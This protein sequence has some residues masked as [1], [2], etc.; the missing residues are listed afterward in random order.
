LR[1]AWLLI[2]LASACFGVCAADIRWRTPM[3]S[4]VAQDKPLKDFIREFAASQ[5]VTVLVSKEIEGTISGKFNL[6]PASMLEL[7]ATAHGLVWFFDGNVL[8]IYPATEFA[9]QVI[10]LN[11]ASIS[12]LRESL[13][14]LDL[15]DKRFPVVYDT[16][17]N[18]VFV[19]GP[20]RYVDLVQQAARAVEDDQDARQATDIRVFPMKYAWAADFTF[21]QGGREQTLPGVA[22]V[23]RSLY[24]KQQPGTMHGLSGVA[25][26]PSART[27]ATLR[28]LQG[29][30]VV[31]SDASA[32]DGGLSAEADSPSGSPAGG[33][34]LP[35]FQP[36][37]RLNAVLVRDLPE[38]MPFYEDVIRA[39]DVR[40]GL[41]E[42]EARVI[43][44]SSD[45]VESL[46]IDWRAHGRH[47][48]VQLGRGA[49]PTLDPLTALTTGSSG[50][51][52]NGGIATVMFGD[53]GNFLLAR[54]NALAEQGKANVLSSPR[55]LTL[56]NVEAAMENISTF[57]VRVAGN[58][59]ASLFDVST[60]TSL[61]VTPLIVAEGQA[62]QIKLAVRIEDGDVDERLVDGIPVVKRSTITTQAFIK[63]GDSL[64]VGGYN[65]QSRKSSEV[66]VPGL[67]AMPVLGHLFK[68][69]EQREK[70]VE[71][72]FLLTPRIVAL[73]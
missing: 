36:D 52:P 60:G 4:Y 14:R 51:A 27:R 62:R 63:E 59:D 1:R 31:G 6:T 5:G 16:K 44:V 50:V 55:V 58:L 69:R 49:I 20:K 71:R 32:A 30:G 22:S 11:S 45:E 33:A 53:A 43:E 40:P 10:H 3:F 47:A 48:D 67:S 19:S 41:V 56:D 66:G 12:R 42:I 7:V 70:R 54:I 46:G 15:A 37:G 72:L 57:F 2:V 61:R 29:L 26:K 39:L 35:Q 18:T 17:R 64:L 28:K 65:Q 34:E 73:P 25:A 8:F 13:E 21:V 23:L 68:Y 9:S 38:R 24:V